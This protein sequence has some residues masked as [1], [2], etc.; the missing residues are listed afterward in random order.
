MKTL[1][2]FASTLVWGFR[3]FQFACVR[4]FQGGI[5]VRMVDLEWH[6]EKRLIFRPVL[7]Y[8]G[9]VLLYGSIRI[10]QKLERVTEHKNPLP[11]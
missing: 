7:G 2:T 4:S 3:G 9:R 5:R 11:A 6:Q 1:S 10:M 8:S